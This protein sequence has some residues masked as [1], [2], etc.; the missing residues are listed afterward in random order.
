MPKSS[1]IYDKDRLA[2]LRNRDR[3]KQ[4]T[5]LI[6]M[7]MWLSVQAIQ[8]QSRGQWMISVEQRLEALEGK[9]K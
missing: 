6:V 2:R 7:A 3:I 4:K 8:L 5:I 1:A 9:G